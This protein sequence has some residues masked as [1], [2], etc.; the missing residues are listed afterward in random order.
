MVLRHPCQGEGTLDIL[1]VI[2][3]I[4]NLTDLDYENLM[5]DEEFARNSG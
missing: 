2:T 1:N 3:E 4:E 5:V